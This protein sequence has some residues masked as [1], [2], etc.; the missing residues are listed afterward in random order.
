[1]PEKEH[2]RT[3]QPATGLAPREKRNIQLAHRRTTIV[4]EPYMWESIDDLLAR[5]QLDLSAF[6]RHVDQTRRHSSLA[7]ATRQVVLTYFRILHSISTP[8]FLNNTLPM[9]LSEPAASPPTP[10]VI[11]L[12][13]RRFAQEEMRA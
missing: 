1:M 4:L 5:E 6:C 9:G 10:P 2:P 12:A 7:S 8:P 13:M 11:E 3:E